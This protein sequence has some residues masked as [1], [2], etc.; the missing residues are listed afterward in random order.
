MKESEEEKTKNSNKEKIKKYKKSEDFSKWYNFVVQSARLADYSPIKGFMFILPYGY[1]IWENIKNILDKKLKES[2]H[3]NAYAPALIPESLLKKE[4]EHVKGFSPECFWVTFSGDNKLSEKLALRPTSETIIYH[5]YAKLIRSW[6]DLP[7]LLNFWNSVFRAEIKMTKLFIRTCEFLWQEGHTAHATEEDAKE[8]IKKI[9]SIYRELIEEYIAIPTLYGKKSESEKFPGAKETY[10][11]EG[12]MPDGK[13]L[14]LGTVH[15]LGQNFAKVFGIKF[16]DRDEK[17][18]FVWQTC[19]GVSTRLIG[20]MLMVHGDDHGAIIPP[21]IAPIQVV[22]IPIIYKDK[23]EKVF[24]KCKE[25]K[26]VLEDE[27]RI[28]L[29]DRKDYTPGWKFNEWELKGVPLRIEI[30]PMDIENNKVTLVRRDNFERF[31]VDEYMIKNVVRE[32]LEEIQT[33]L[34]KKAEKF[35]KD[36]IFLARDYQEFKKLIKKGFVKACLCSS[37]SCE[38]RIKEETGATIRLIPLENEEIF[39]NC[40]SCNKKSEI[41]AY[42]ARGY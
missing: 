20:A 38:E 36:N 21:R 31:V 5:F 6:R 34:Y 24:E 39:S 11:L 14:Q 12:L 32:K 42:F 1:E 22:I 13:A 17:K 3:K 16:L 29:D 30:G 7:L 19:W 26:K 25:I 37:R 33:N 40:I 27:F 4:K 28:Y 35:L 41:V 18:K 15:N 2:G 8:E 23:E 9:I 10:T